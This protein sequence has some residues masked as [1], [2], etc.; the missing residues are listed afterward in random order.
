MNCGVLQFHLLNQ[1]LKKN[2][3]IV[4]LSTFLISSE[5]PITCLM[6]LMSFCCLRSNSI[7]KG[8]TPPKSLDSKGSLYLTLS[9]KFSVKRDN[10]PHGSLSLVQVQGLHRHHCNKFGPNSKRFGRG[11]HPIDRKSTRLNS[12]HFQVSRMP[13][14]A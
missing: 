11:T 8:K 1:S 10:Y 14:S 3:I 4:I 2:Q 7:S 13:S 5:H 6:T 9:M 12:S